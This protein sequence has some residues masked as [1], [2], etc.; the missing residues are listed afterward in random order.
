MNPVGVDAAVKQTVTRC[1]AGGYVWNPYYTQLADP[2]NTDLYKRECG[3][4]N[5]LRCY[6]GDVSSRIGTLGSLSYHKY[7]EHIVYKSH[8]IDLTGRR[9]V[10]SDPNLPLE[11]AISALGRSIVIF[12]PERSS[13]RYACA[14]IE[15]DHNIVKFIN[16]QKPPRFVV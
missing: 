3:L 13:E 9:I 16:L 2:L 1:V 11:G 5:P 10:I 14:N 15:P 6:V 7:K 8:V 4:D 12:G